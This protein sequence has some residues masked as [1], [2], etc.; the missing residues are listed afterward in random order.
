MM[1][2]LK[3][4]RKRNITRINSAVFILYNYINSNFIVTKEFAL[5][6]IGEVIQKLNAA[7]LDGT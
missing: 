6:G 7:A 1:K 4:F 3:I 2:L 5:P